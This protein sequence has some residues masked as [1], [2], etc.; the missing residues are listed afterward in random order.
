MKFIN[1]GR[2]LKMTF[3]IKETYEYKFKPD[4]WR[5]FV[6]EMWYKHKD[7][8]FTW[9]GKVVTDYNINDYFKDNKWFLKKKFKKLKEHA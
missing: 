8:I 9:T 1:N 4:V 7:E 5:N 6:T 3:Q 2:K